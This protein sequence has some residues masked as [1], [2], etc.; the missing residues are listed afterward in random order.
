VI[1]FPFFKEG[2]EE[3]AKWLRRIQNEAKKS[4]NAG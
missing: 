4:G 1:P 2:E 3:R